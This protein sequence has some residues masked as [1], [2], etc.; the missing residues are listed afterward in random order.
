MRSILHAARDLAMNVL[1]KNVTFAFG[2]GQERKK[3]NIINIVPMLLV[4]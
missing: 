3:V 2:R 4:A 1:I